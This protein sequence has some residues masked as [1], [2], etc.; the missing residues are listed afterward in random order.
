[1][2]ALLTWPPCNL[3]YC[4]KPRIGQIF[5]FLTY[6]WE[7][8]E[9]EENSPHCT[10]KRMVFLRKK[11]IPINQT[12]TRYHTGHNF[13]SMWGLQALR[14]EYFSDA[15]LL[16][17]NF[18]L[19]ACPDWTCAAQQFLRDSA[20]S[21]EIK[22]RWT[23]AILKAKKYCQ[24]PGNHFFTWWKRKSIAGSRKTSTAPTFSLSICGQCLDA[25]WSSPFPS[26]WM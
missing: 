16:H 22:G 17:P 21:G 12:K 2:K 11:K 13:C 4:F 8:R 19:E 26:G 14:F 7:M 24:N 5:F 20:A 9:D 10:K 6:L 18:F 25:A 23:K 1:M 15:Y 3:S